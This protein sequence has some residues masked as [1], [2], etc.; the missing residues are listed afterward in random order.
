[1]ETQAEGKGSRGR[2]GTSRAG[3]KTAGLV[4]SICRAEGDGGRADVGV[5]GVVFSGQGQRTGGLT[6]ANGGTGSG[7]TGGIGSSGEQM[8]SGLTV[9]ARGTDW[10]A[11]RV[12]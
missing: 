11:G 1:M 2:D 6:A 10:A 9:R 4:G 7:G 3:K 12:A 5:A 8:G